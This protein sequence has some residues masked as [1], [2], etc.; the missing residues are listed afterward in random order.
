MLMFVTMHSVQ[1]MSSTNMILQPLIKEVGCDICKSLCYQ[2]YQITVLLDYMK[3]HSKGV[4]QPTTLP[5][6][7]DST[8]KPSTPKPNT[9]KPTQRKSHFL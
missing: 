7:K 6:T 8:T 9:P 1:I 5:P 4:A 2:D 3:S